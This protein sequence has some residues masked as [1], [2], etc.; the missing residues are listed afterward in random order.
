VHLSDGTARRVASYD[1]ARLRQ[2]LD[3]E[4]AAGRPYFA[5]RGLVVVPEVTIENMEAAA[6]GLVEEGYSD[7]SDD[8][9][10]PV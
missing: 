2:T 6:R 4:C 8:E 1:P 3:D 7:A 5:E 9:R 10:R